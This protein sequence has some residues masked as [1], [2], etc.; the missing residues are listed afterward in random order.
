MGDISSSMIRVPLTLEAAGPY[1]YRM[2]ETITG[3]LDRLRAQ[4]E[5]LRDT[6][7][8]VAQIYYD[9]HKL[10]W[11]SAAAGLFGPNCVLASIGHVM[12]VNWNNYDTC[13]Y[14]NAMTFRR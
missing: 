10:E 3:D 13:E 12:N 1:M 7:Q 14:S 6:W 4:L 2:V 9:A 11:D 8:G 5:P